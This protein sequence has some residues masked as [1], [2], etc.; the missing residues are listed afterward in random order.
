MRSRIKTRLAL[1]VLT[2]WV[3]STGTAHAYLDPG[4]GSLLLQ[5]L[6]GGIAGAAVFIKIYWHKILS[7]FKGSRTKQQKRDDE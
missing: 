6:L 4:T 5:G 3:I 2:F 1:Y 7:W